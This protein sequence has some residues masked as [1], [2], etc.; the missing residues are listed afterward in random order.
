MNDKQKLFLAV[1]FLCLALIG[2]ARDRKYYREETGVLKAQS[3]A[4]DGVNT[5]E[6]I[7]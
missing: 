2:C 3:R 6:F 1:M 5:G 4:A 7:K